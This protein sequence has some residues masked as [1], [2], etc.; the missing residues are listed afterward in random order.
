MTDLKIVAAMFVDS[1]LG[2]WRTARDLF[3]NRAP[4]FRIKIGNTPARD[5][6]HH[7]SVKVPAQNHSTDPD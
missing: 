4:G 5:Y 7:F 1:L 2:S 3:G 6:E